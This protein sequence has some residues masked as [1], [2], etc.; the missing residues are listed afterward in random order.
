MV[1]PGMDHG[2]SEA[3]PTQTDQREAAVPAVTAELDASATLETL[4]SASK[5]IAGS[6]PGGR[7]PFKTGGIRR[8]SSI[9]MVRSFARLCRMYGLRPGP[10]MALPLQRAVTPASCG[11]SDWY[12]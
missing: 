5:P 1:V 4:L 2:W 11:A 10:A 8:C 12:P 9:E 3:T 7:N 6:I